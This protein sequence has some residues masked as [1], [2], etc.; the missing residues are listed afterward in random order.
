MVSC[1]KLSIFLQYFE[2]ILRLL[3]FTKKQKLDEVQKFLG[4]PQMNLTSHQV[5]IHRGPLWEHIENWND[6]NKTL[7]GTPYE[8]FL[9]VD[10]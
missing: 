9:S 3:I 7:G 1:L 8:S 2:I 5:K 10:Y 4:L 6:V